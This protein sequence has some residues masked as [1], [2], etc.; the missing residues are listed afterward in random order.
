[1]FKIY[2]TK[3]RPS[4]DVE[5]FKPDEEYRKHF[6]INYIKTGK[7]VSSKE[8]VSEDGLTVVSEV[9]WKSIEDYVDFLVDKFCR[10]K[11]LNPSKIYNQEHNIKTSM[12]E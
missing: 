12:R 5:F 11:S 2:L 6:F 1:M 8:D 9:V 3:T 4:I 10:Q 7:F